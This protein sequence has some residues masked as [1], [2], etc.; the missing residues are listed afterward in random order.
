MATQ[1]CI[2]LVEQASED[3]KIAV[4]N[5][6]ILPALKTIL[7]DPPPQK[8]LDRG[9]RRRPDVPPNNFAFSLGLSDSD[10]SDDSDGGMFRILTRPFGL[11]D[12]MIDVPKNP[13]NEKKAKS[14]GAL[15]NRC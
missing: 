7:D 8:G 10:D 14:I 13:A 1:I 15:S 6:G 4:A 12:G 3:D 11:N 2:T 5:S 9:P